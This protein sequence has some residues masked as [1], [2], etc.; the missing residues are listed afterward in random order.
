MEW[1]MGKYASSYNWKSNV[2]YIQ[3]KEEEK[4][5]VISCQR[6]RLMILLGPLPTTNKFRKSGYIIF[7]Y[8]KLLMI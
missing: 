3:K 5:N 4:S 8:L 7:L 2:I 1:G 6:P